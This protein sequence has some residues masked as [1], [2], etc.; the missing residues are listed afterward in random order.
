MDAYMFII[1]TTLESMT[2]VDPMQKW[3]PIEKFYFVI[4]SNQHEFLVLA[5]TLSWKNFQISLTHM[6]SIREL[7]PDIKTQRG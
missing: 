7:Y 4:H 3:K 2:V 5:S 1:Q 6:H